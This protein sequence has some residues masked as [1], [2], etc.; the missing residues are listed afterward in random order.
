MILP[1]S[2]LHFGPPANHIVTVLLRGFLV[3]TN[4]VILQNGDIISISLQ[5]E[6]EDRS[7]SIPLPSNGTKPEICGTKYIF[8]FF[9]I[10]YPAR[11]GKST[12]HSFNIN[13]PAAKC[14]TGPDL[15]TSSPS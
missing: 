9:F 1:S 3:S 10:P 12:C 5:K 7:S 15:V 2:C 11:T 6:K 8:S 13:L 4:L 14:A